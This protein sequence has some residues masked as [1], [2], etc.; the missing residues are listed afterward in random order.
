MLTIIDEHSRFPFVY[1]CPTTDTNTVTTCLSQLFSLFGMPACVHSD[2]EPSFMS[3]EF[4]QW[5]REKGIATSR[6]TPY[7]PQGN[8]Q[9]ERY[10]GI[11]YKTVE[12]A[13]KTK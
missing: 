9:T 3:N 5:L 8:G 1:P 13:L 11:I 6:T 12:L 10:N 7:N 4:K 2:R